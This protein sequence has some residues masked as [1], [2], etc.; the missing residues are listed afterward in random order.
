MP[1]EVVRAILDYDLH[2]RAVGLPS[3]QICILAFV[4]GGVK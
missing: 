2:K 1:G 4:K 3:V